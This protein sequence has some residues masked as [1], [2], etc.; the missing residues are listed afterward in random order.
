MYEELH[1]VRLLLQSIRN[2]EMTREQ[3][4]DWRLAKPTRIH[5]TGT[6]QY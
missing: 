3:V 4:N 5:L 2:G 1:L 6:K